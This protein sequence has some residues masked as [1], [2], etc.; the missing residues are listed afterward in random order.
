MVVFYISDVDVN[1]SE[2]FVSAL[3]RKRLK[4]QYQLQNSLF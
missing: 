4:V 1:A 2:T 3:F